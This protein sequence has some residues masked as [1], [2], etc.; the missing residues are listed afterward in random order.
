MRSRVLYTI[1][2]T[3]FLLGCGSSV[4]ESENIG[5]TTIRFSIPQSGHVKL[6]IENSYDTIEITL[7][8]QVLPAG[9]YSV[10]I[11]ADTLKEGVYFYKLQLDDQI[12]QDREMIVIGG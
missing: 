5:L 2:P 4:V 11:P 1:M 9:T 10:Q 3:L 6:F 8:D 12:L 7:V